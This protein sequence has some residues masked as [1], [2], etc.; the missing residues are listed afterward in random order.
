[1]NGGPIEEGG[2]VAQSA[3]EGLRGSPGLLA[4]VLL[5]VATIAALIYVAQ[6]NRDRDAKREMYM[7]EFCLDGQHPSKD[8]LP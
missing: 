1:M 7:L 3:I 2:K 5:Q 4:V 6:L 8:K